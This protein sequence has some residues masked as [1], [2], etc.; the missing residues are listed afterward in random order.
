M[1]LS[2][3]SRYG[4]R[5]IVRLAFFQQEGS[6]RVKLEQ[7]AKYEGVSLKYLEAIFAALKRQ[8]LVQS[9]KG[10]SG[11]YKLRKLPAEITAL[12]VV[13]ALEG[14]ITPVDCIEDKNECNFDPAKCSVSKLWNELNNVI[15]NYLK[16]KTIAEIINEIA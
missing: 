15:K 3:F 14:S 2:T 9:F 11:G 8:K 4:M 16:S 7:I 13:E 10:R 5:A 6:G 12:E 1:Q